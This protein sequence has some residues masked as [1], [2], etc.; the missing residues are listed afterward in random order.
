MF[1]FKHFDLKNKDFKSKVYNEIS[2]SN[3]KISGASIKG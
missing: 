2:K 1:G 3:G